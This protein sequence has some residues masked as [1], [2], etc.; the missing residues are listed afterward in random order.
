MAT[1]ASP[2]VQSLDFCDGQYGR[3]IQSRKFSRNSKTVLTNESLEEVHMES[4]SL[5]FVKMV[6]FAV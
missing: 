6:F 4:E 1:S 3:Q 2:R 5:N